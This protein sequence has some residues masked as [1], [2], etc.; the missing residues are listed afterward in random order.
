MKPNLILLTALLLAPLSALQAALPIERSSLVTAELDAAAFVQWHNGSA[1]PISAEQAK[2]GPAA[3]VWTARTDPSLFGIRFGE[4]REPGVRH[5]RI[6]F[7]APVAIGSVLVR[8]GG[9]LSVLKADAAYPGDLSDDTLWI[10]ASRLKDGAESQA[11]VGSGSFG[12]WLLPAGTTTRALRFTHSPAPGDREMS[13]SLGGVWLHDKRLLN[14]APQALAQSSGRDDASAKLIDERHNDWGTWD[15]GERG[16]EQRIDESHPEIVTLT[17]P[18]AVTLSGV[19]LLWNG[20]G[21]ATFDA[22]TGPDD[23]NVRAAP[24][25]QWQRLTEAS[26][27][28]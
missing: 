4:G 14:L 22:F 27:L 15:N 16:A 3:V 11:E 12:L 24:E 17:W 9:T 21:S 26:K 10:T 6:G 2:N 20:F 5:L 1:I 13:G 23:A 18:R 7:A 25:A 19:C 8:G 28:D